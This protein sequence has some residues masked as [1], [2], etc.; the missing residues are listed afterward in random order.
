MHTHL[1]NTIVRLA[2]IGPKFL[3]IFFFILILILI[4][5]LFWNLG[6]GLE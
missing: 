1:L 6:L 3:L 2:N 4:D 5:F